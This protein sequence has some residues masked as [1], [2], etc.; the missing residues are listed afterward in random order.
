[1]SVFGKLHH[2][3]EKKAFECV[4]SILRE[5]I[6]EENP[7]LKMKLYEHRHSVVAFREPLTYKK[8]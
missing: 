4:L 8:K 3:V 2:H 7:I 6:V 5:E 1:M